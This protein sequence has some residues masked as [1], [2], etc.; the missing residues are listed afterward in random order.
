VPISIIS[1]QNIGASLGQQFVDKS[2][3][4]GLLAFILIAIFMIGFYRLPGLLSVIAL[5][6]YT[7]INVVIF[8]SIPVTLTLS[9]IA[10]FVLSAGMAVD[11]NVLIFERMKEELGWG[12]PL[13]TASEEGF[14]RAWPSIRD[15]NL[16]TL[17]SCIFLYWF[18][19]SMIRGF[20]LTLFIGVVTSML[21]ALIITRTFMNT[22]IGWKFISNNASWLFPK[23]NFK[24]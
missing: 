16:T 3:M 15:G 23:K 1:Q 12:K 11:A 22:V 14:K 13:G 4:A 20:A 19:S 5:F 6:I 21:S 17:L 18:G 8:K 7:I 9:G 2:L 10:G 24:K